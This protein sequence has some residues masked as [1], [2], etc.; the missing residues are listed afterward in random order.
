MEIWK[1]VT[2]LRPP[3]S[4]YLTVGVVAQRFVGLIY[5]H[6]LD[7]SGRTGLSGQ[8]VDHDL[9]GEEEDPLGPPYLLSLLGSGAPFRRTYTGKERLSE[10]Q[11]DVRSEN[12]ASS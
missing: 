9:R 5:H 6:T 1:A 11:K 8:V 12:S 3:I 10:M 2:R 4:G 7:L